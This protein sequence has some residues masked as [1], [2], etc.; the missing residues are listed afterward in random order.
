MH[1]TRHTDPGAFLE[2]AAPMTA[3]GAASASFFVGWA[4]ALKRRPSSGGE[5]HYL[6][7]CGTAGAA[8]RRDGGPAIVGQSDAE[9][10]AAFAGDLAVDC[11]EL[12]GVVG[13]AAA[14]EAFAQRWRL[15]TGRAHSLR[16]RLRQH[17]LT[18]VAE[19]PSAPGA[20]RTSV[21]ADL[22]WLAD[23]QVALM[24]EVGMVDSVER[25][26]AG[27][28]ERIVRGEFRVWDDDEPVAY[29]GFNDAAPEFAR[30]APVYTFSHRRGRGYATALVA[31]LARELLSRGKQRLFLT[32]DAA[33][34]TS[35]AIY[36]RIGFVAENDECHFDFVDQRS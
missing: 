32:T 1:V 6:A 20:V 5:G 7:T 33:N 30:I 14:C 17:V 3:R 25:M 18:G 4:H 13:S 35:N 21:E 27:L 15:L 10:A 8:I 29:A 28:P 36:A 34:P 24:R 31:E 19:V 2:A 11:P 22:A 12:Q 26:L 9:A 23:A 16:V